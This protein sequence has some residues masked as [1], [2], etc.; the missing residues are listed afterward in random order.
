MHWWLFPFLVMVFCSPPRV[1]AR[2]ATPEEKRE[3]DRLYAGL[4]PVLTL[5]I[6]ETELENLRKNPRS[7]VEAVLEEKGGDTYKHVA[8]KL[9][10][11]AGSF[12]GI[13]A[14]PGFSVNMEKF[15]GGRPFHGVTRFQLNNSV[16]D[17]SALRELLAGEI[18]RKAGVP[19]SR[20]TH[21]I[22]R[23]NDKYLGLYVLKEAFREDFLAA[24]FKNTGGRLYESAFCTEIRKEMELDRGD[25]SDGSRLVELV[26]ALSDPDGERQLRRVQ[27]AIEV[28][29]YIRYVALEN[30]LCHWDGYSFNRNNYRIYEDPDSRKF[31]FFLHGMDQTFGDS[32]WSLLRTPGAAVGAILWRDAG[33]RARYAEVV[34]E[35]VEKVLRP[36]SWPE[37]A[38]EVG[39]RVQGA[40]SAEDPKKGEAYA[41][42]IAAARQLIQARMDSCARQIQATHLLMKLAKGEAASL[43]GFYW[44]A[45]GDNAKSSEIS[46]DGRRV[47]L[48]QATGECKASWRCALNL[49]PG[50]YRFEGL[51][52]TRGVVAAETP[53]GS[54]AGLRIS[55]GSR[56]GKTALAEN[57]N[58]T[59]MRFEFES[60]GGE[61]VLVAELCAR[62][63]ELWIDRKSLFIRKMP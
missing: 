35:L 25:A 42:K 58:W 33:V 6:A 38:E 22:V 23:L 45:Q 13:D 56:A 17:E 61:Q 12:Q 32:N 20:C 19:A 63:G 2:A 31:H 15:K 57:R 28:E 8:V 14:R 59:E 54:G 1:N 40:L 46:H 9:K 47:L 24:F 51:L 4:I 52:G 21:A 55:G 30:I 18:A 50:K 34:R 44:A 3:A 49:P 10:G 16:Q 7:Y 62:A 48:I 5:R 39:R 37:R 36:L 53:S 60:A 29:A 27:A 41:G 11:S 26:E 43:E